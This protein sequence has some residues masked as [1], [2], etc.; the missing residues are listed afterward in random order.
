MKT[1][2]WL[3]FGKGGVTGA[4]CATPEDA[5]R[6]IF[7]KHPRMRSCKVRN[8]TS[9]D[10]GLFIVSMVA[11]E[12]REYARADI[13]VATLIPARFERATARGFVWCDGVKIITPSGTEI[14]PYMSKTDARAYCKREGWIATE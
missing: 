14:Q 1:T 3:A 7:T 11:H 8:G 2:E 10:D 5:A 13:M 4:S 9:R 12:I 6:D